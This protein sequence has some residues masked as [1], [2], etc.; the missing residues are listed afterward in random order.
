MGY[1]RGDSPI[2]R[3]L[4]EIKLAPASLAIAFATRVLPQPGGPYRRTPVAMSIPNAYKS[5]CNQ[6][7]MNKNHPHEILSK[8]QSTKISPHLMFNSAKDP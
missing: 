7:N 3:T 5:H 1:V 6:K 4:T 2:Q 8:L